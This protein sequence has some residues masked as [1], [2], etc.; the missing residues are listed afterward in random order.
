MGRWRWR[1]IIWRRRTHGSR[2]RRWRQRLPVFR[3]GPRA[4]EHHGRHPGRQRHHE[5]QRR[6]HDHRQLSF[7]KQVVSQTVCKRRSN[8]SGPQ[9]PLFYCPRVISPQCSSAN[10]PPSGIARHTGT[11]YVDAMLYRGSTNKLP[12]LA[13]N[14]GY[15]CLFFNP[16]L[17]FFMTLGRE[18]RREARSSSG[19]RCSTTA[20]G[21]TKHSTTSV[22]CGM[23][24]RPLFLKHVSVETGTPHSDPHYS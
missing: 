16:S 11:S 5:H 20:S 12:T 3:P 17:P 6:V 9:G 22:R 23:K 19:S 1:R 21:Y 7:R 18:L 14:D 4:G 13:L 10:S 8:R 24:S 2:W 15:D